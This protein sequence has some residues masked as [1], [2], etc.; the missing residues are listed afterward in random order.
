MPDNKELVNMLRAVIQEELKPINE[1]LDRV[2]QGQQETNKRL[3][4]IE[5]AV[6]DLKAI[7]RRS[8]KEAFSQLNAIW[9][10]VKRIE[11]RLDVQ[12]KKSI[13]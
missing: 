12:E 4:P 13:R 11:N 6:N 1:R 10:D 5:A 3:T 8:H 9:D 2:E 7:N